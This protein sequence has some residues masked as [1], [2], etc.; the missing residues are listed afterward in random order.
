MNRNNNVQL[1]LLL[2]LYYISA[3]FYY[4]TMEEQQFENSTG[5]T[6]SQFKE[7][8]DLH[9]NQL[10]SYIYYRSGDEELASDIAQDCFMKIWEIREKIKLKTLS[11]LLYTMAGN[12]YISHKRYNKVKFNFRLNTNF[13]IADYSPEEKYIFHETKE[14][15]ERIL[16]KM[17]EK[18]RTTF[19][20]SRIDGLTY[21]EIAQRLRLSVKAVEKR[22]SSALKLFK[23]NL[24]T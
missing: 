22:M 2:S 24:K 16:E 11:S 5:L 1:Y 21:S 7:A 17:P 20:L 13:G 18:Q 9:F 6:S 10:R 14:K 23:S 15:Y 8:F 3:V 19:L 4:Q 12:L